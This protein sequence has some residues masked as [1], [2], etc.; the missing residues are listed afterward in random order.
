MA[1]SLGGI[2]ALVFSAGIGEHSPEVRAATCRKLR[3]LGLKLE[4]E[5]NSNAEPD[6]NIAGPDSSVSV[7]VIQAQEDWA[8]ARECARLNA[9][10]GH[11]IMT[12]HK[13][14]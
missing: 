9:L 13:G 12:I 5:K 11:V 7:L 4:E 14:R 10:V 8:I 3:F 1:A 6:V 2:D